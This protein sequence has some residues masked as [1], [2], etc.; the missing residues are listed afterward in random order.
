M[1]KDLEYYMGLNYPV[2]ILKLSKEDGGGYHACI[3]FLDK[4]VFVGYGDDINEAL[5]NLNDIKEEWFETYL[6]KGYKI[7]EPDELE[8]EEYSGR[9]IV[10]IPKSMHSIL[11]SEA[12]KQN[13]SLNYYVGTL[14]TMNYF[15]EKSNTF[16]EDKICRTAEKYIDTFNEGKSKT[17]NVEGWESFMK[18]ILPIS[19][20]V[21]AESYG[22]PSTRHKKR[23]C[24][25]I[26]TLE[27]H[28][29]PTLEV[30]NAYNYGKY[31]NVEN[32]EKELVN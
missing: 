26:N 3:P 17:K 20:I 29:S 5:S 8:N 16:L 22:L 19:A 27:I 21:E 23:N 1:K 13:V 25:G 32:N 12:K 18:E 24:I 6:E 7:S 11:S 15:I 30:R 2:E 14:L 10:R 4:K 9:F 28:Q 31:I